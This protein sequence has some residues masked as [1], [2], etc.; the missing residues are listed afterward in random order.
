MLYGSLA[1][2]DRTIKILHALGYANPNDWS[3]PIP[4]PPS[5]AVG[6]VTPE[7]TAIAHSHLWM[8]ILTKTILP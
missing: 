4:V 7:E 5:Q 3:G 6:T 8:V 2:I 1:E